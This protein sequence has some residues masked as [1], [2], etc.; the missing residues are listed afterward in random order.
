MSFAGAERGAGFEPL[1]DI[2]Y[3]VTLAAGAI[4]SHTVYSLAATVWFSRFPHRRHIGH[5]DAF[6]LS[7]PHTIS[8]AILG[9]SYVQR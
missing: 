1:G 6:A 5:F 2:R 7:P 3:P 4:V 9:T 8:T